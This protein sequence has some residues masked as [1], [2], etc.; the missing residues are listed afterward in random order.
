MLGEGLSV[1]PGFPEG[2]GYQPVDLKRARLSVRLSVTL[3]F[4]F[5]LG[6]N[7]EGRFRADRNLSRDSVLPPRGRLWPPTAASGRHV[8]RERR[9]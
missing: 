7:S 8:E 6:S 3:L 1:N 2:R 4:G 5:S 9:E